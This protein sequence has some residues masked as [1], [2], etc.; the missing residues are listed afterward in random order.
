V[1]DLE[2]SRGAVA[3]AFVLLATLYLISLFVPDPSLGWALD[4]EICCHVV[5]IRAIQQEG[6][7]AAVADSQHYRSATT[8]LYHMLM[9]VALGHDDAFLLRIMWSVATLLVGVL[10]YHHV[11]TDPALRHGRTAAIALAITFLL[12]PTVRAS[13]VYFVTDGLA[14]H[15]AIAA[16]V[17]LRHA[18]AGRSFSALLGLLAVFVA[19]LSFYTRQYYL[20]VTLYVAYSVFF[21]LSSRSVKTATIAA[22]LLLSAPALYLFRIWHGLTPPLDFPILTQPSL[23]STVPNALGLVAV[24]SL[25]LVWIGVGDGARDL[26]QKVQRGQLWIPM[27][28]GMA[29]YVASGLA[30]GFEI[31]QAGG[32]LRVVSLFGSFGPVVF[33]AISSLGL[34]VLARWLMVDGAGQLW[35]AVF[36]LPLLVGSV[37]L[38]RYFE[39]AILVFMFLVARPRDAITVLDSRLVWFYPL[40]AAMYALSRTIYFASNL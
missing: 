3:A 24:Y 9:S 17:L 2:R 39:P 7:I 5:T 13:A 31:P 23:L 22:C 28:C 37:L 38:Q 6:L 35:W 16:L 32:I 27:A 10:L 26:Q 12:S 14:V 30:L 15:L 34:F 20:W 8:P 40:F 4:D 21:D 29:L 25:P 1:V 19:F 33:L 36:L 18:R 11:R